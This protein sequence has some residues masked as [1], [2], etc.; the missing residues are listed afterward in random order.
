MITTRAEHCWVLDLPN[1]DTWE[2]P[3]YNSEADAR[4]AT[5]NLTDPDDP[6]HHQTRRLDHLCVT[7]ACNGCGTTVGD[8]F[9]DVAMAA[10]VARDAGF[11]VDHLNVWCA[12]CHP[13]TSDPTLPELLA[14]SYPTGD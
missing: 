14:A 2:E 13:T 11:H 10:A 7:A 1:S 8:D 4:A 12:T 6:D 3:H 5:A 9:P